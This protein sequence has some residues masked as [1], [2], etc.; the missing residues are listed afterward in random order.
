MN[1]DHFGYY[2]VGTH[3]T[4]SK[5]EAL[6]L[7]HTLNI[8][9]EWV[10][11]DRLFDSHPWHID[12]QIDIKQFYKQ[13]AE[14]IR[15]KYDYIVLWYS[16]GAD[17]FNMTNTFKENNIHVEEIA[18]FHAFEGEKSWNSYL[19]QEI[20]IVAIPQTKEF[21]NAMPHTRHRLVDLTQLVKS[22][23]G[24]DG[25]KFDFIYKSNHSFGP[26]QLARTYLREKIEDWS[27]IISSG[28]KLCFVWAHDKPPVRYDHVLNKYYLEFFD[29]VDGAGVGPRIQIENRSDWHD[30]FFYWSPDALD[31]ITRQAHIVVNY[32]RNPPKQDL[33]SIYLTRDPFS[34]SLSYDG[35]YIPEYMPRPTMRINGII[36]YLTVEGLHR[37]IYPGWKEDTFTNRKPYGYIFSPRDRWWF[38]AHRGDDQKRFIGAIQSYY[39]KFTKWG[40]NNHKRNS[41]DMNLDLRL[42]KIDCL[43]TKR[44]Y[45][46]V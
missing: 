1:K 15:N 27:K 10:F 34:Y 26:H 7:A 8:Q 14:Y 5:I 42:L 20:E 13:R 4:Y 19:N 29:S 39:K 37:L 28:K 16:G 17:S 46:E 31:T 40:F 30:E 25:N 11:N 44:Y 23:F 35:S 9:P 12:T 36:Y 6:E 38:D 43:Y 2:V 41:A 22:V 3:K 45:L 33:D 21:L 32:L 18:Q 24:E